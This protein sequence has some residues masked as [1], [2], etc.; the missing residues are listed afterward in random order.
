MDRRPWALVAAVTIAA[1]AAAVTST[2]ALVLGS[3][4]ERLLAAGIIVLALLHLG[5]IVMRESDRRLRL[6]IIGHFDN[7][8]KTIAR[9]L[10][11]LTQRVENCE[12]DIQQ[13]ETKKAEPEPEPIPAADP[14]GLTGELDELRRSLRKLAEEHGVATDAPPPPPAPA[15][16]NPLLADK[17]FRLELYL[18]PIVE[19]KTNATKHYRASLVLETPQG[20]AVPF[21]EL[22][23]EA[24]R[25]RLRA[26]LDT[27]C[28]SR[29][30]AVARRLIAKQPETFVI[31]PVGP[32]TLSSREALDAI[33]KLLADDRGTALAIIF[34]IDHAV[35]AALDTA[36]IQG[37]ARLARG[38]GGLSLGRAHGLG[39]DLKALRSLRFRF[40]C[41]GAANLSRDA[42]AVPAW[43]SVAR[44]A[45]ESGFEIALQG[46]PQP[47]QSKQLERWA[48]LASG[49]GFA[50]PRKVKN[51]IALVRTER[52]AA[53]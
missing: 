52:S 11:A 21:E 26:D 20:R 40:I 34:E 39:V 13:R 3:G 1:A 30:L 50:T 32:E 23:Y 29:A 24:G 18:E 51:D 53:A 4:I 47:G 36:G 5:Y 12:E 7:R 46:V 19:L 41:F 16:E 48:T 17:R 9:D 22:S 49:S 31:V 6:R 44:V 27:H 37:L 2:L 33:A 45:A 43:A 35:M 14:L 38:G 42:L 28:L 10:E 8:A 25:H 15:P